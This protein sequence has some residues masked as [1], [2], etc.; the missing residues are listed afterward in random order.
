LHACAS[1]VR[2][3]T[4][5]FASDC[6]LST[7][8]NWCER[9][10]R[11]RGGMRESDG[12]HCALNA[13]H[14]HPTMFPTLGLF[15]KL[16]CPHKAH[17][18]RPNCLF[19]HSPEVT[20]VPT[21][22]IPV[23]IPKPLPQ[24]P[25]SAASSSKTPSAQPKTSYVVPVKRPVGSP[26]RAPATPPSVEPPSKLKRMGTTQ[27]PIAIP[28]L[29]YTSVSAPLY[30]RVFRTYKVFQE[31]APLLKV[32]AAQSQVALPV[33]QVRVIGRLLEWVG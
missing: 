14:A 15:Q 11:I 12:N 33:R 25:P 6:W 24:T 26:F 31:G 8:A 4:P 5:C 30:V 1:W 10:A 18:E 23:D 28:T 9:N 2:L 16:P 19:S 20:Q 13:L 21:V 17:C 29:A 27:R 22:S 7:T 3:R 32:N